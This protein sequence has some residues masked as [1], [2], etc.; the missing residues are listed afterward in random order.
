MGAMEMEEGAHLDI[1][2]VAYIWIP[3]EFETVVHSEAF[4]A[5]VMNPIERISEIKAG[6]IFIAAGV[7]AVVLRH[8][9]AAVEDAVAQAD[10]PFAEF[11]IEFGSVWAGVLTYVP[12]VV[13][14]SLKPA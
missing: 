7:G 8:H 1:E 6:A 5:V 13:L 12:A 11:E 9:G 3:E 14:E 2:E 10:V 4:R